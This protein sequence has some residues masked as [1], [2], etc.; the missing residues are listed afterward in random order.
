MQLHLID[1]TFELFRWHFASPSAKAPDGRE[2]SATTGLVHVLARMVTAYE[3]THIA[4]AFDTVIESFRNEL[5]PGYKTGEGVDPALKAQFLLAERAT[6]ALGITTWGMVEF[7]AD[8]AIATAAERWAPDVERVVLGSPDKDLAQCIR[9]DHVVEF[10]SIRKRWIDEEAVRA[11]FGVPPASIP[12]WLGLVGDA[13]DG[14]PGVPKWGAKSTGTVLARYGH[15][16]DIPFDHRMW[17]VAVRGAAGLAESLWAHRDAALL[18]RDLATLRTD[19]PLTETLEDLEWR[20]GRRA[21][22][23]AVCAEIGSTEALEVVTRW[24]TEP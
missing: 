6:H 15:I 17:D 8:D 18:Y 13:A 5:F 24:R 16:E 1:G 3:A 23:E 2:V 12:D 14:L 10:D 9:G 20:G 21:E 7:E 4:V 11:K 22:L 19:V